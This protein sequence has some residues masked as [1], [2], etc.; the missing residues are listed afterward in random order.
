MSDCVE[1]YRESHTR[2]GMGRSYHKQF[3]DGGIRSVYWML[4]K[5]F[6]DGV[7]L[8]RRSTDRALPVLDFACGTGRVSGFLHSLGCS[9]VG[10]DISNSM[11][12]AAESFEPGPNYLQMDLTV[13]NLPIEAVPQEGQFDV[14][15]AF[16]FFPNAQ[17]QLRQEAISALAPLLRRNGLL[18]V[19]H[20]R[21]PRSIWRRLTISLGGP[22]CDLDDRRLV[23]MIGAHGFSLASRKSIGFLPLRHKWKIPTGV[24]WV[25][26]KALSA[27]LGRSTLGQTNLYCF[28]KE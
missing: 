1:D 6:L 22:K 26:E 19:S 27:I 15:T 14:I 17:S 13:E 16:R 2:E 20:H 4:E 8:P 28:V 11:L 10:V 23:E 7:T 12:E 3:V 5:E 25:V 24:V 18:I 9:V 21:N